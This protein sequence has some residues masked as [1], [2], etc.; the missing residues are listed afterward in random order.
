MNINSMKMLRTIV[1]GQLLKG[2]FCVASQIF[3][4]LSRRCTSKRQFPFERLVTKRKRSS[5]SEPDGAPARSFVPI[6]V[7][8]QIRIAFEDHLRTTPRVQH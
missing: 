5:N 3:G 6:P 8:I 2:S 4:D 1:G 7:E